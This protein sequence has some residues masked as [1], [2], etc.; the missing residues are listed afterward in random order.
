[1][2]A[3]MI[4]ISAANLHG[5]ERA[6]EALQGAMDS[7]EVGDGEEWVLVEDITLDKSLQQIPRHSDL[8]NELSLIASAAATLVL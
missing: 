8:C 7:R 5:L 3:D 6:V 2:N 1:M 4:C